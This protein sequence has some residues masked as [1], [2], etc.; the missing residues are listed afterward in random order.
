MRGG[1]EIDEWGQ[2]VQTLRYKINIV[3]VERMAR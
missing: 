2:K 3:G 1:N